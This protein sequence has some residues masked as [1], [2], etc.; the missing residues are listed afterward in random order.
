MKIAGFEISLCIHSLVMT[1]SLEKG[2]QYVI[3]FVRLK[4]FF[5]DLPASGTTEAEYLKANLQGCT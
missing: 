1:L 2:E 5:L 3:N 4:H